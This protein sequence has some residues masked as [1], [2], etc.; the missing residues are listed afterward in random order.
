MEG[1]AIATQDRV[2][3]TG[4]SENTYERYTGVT[5]SSEIKQFQPQD[6]VLHLQIKKIK[7]HNRFM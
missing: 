2:T 4:N 3:N 7:P 6:Q 5:Q 1:F